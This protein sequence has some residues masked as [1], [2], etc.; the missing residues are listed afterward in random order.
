[1]EQQKDCRG[2]TNLTAT[3]TIE[4]ARGLARKLVERE[5]A[6]VGGDVDLAIHRASSLYGVDESALRSL[7]YRWRALTYVK[8]HV[9]ER[10]RHIDEWLE[11][12]AERERAI[13]KDVA[14]TL[15]RRGSPAAGLARSLAQMADET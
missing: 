14:E 1:M 2:T 8:A 5:R 6:K 10:L 12:T 13:A 11:A 9:L 3:A 4:E 15:E 7:R